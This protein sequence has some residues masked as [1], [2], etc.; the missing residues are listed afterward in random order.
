LLLPRTYIQILEIQKAQRRR[1][2]KAQRKRMEILSLIFL[3]KPRCTAILASTLVNFSSLHVKELDLVH[4]RLSSLER[5]RLPRF[6]THLQRLCLRQNFI[7]SL[8][9]EIFSLLTKLVELDL[10]DNK[11]KHI[12]DALNNLTALT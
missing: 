8:D 5:L 11:I 12:G 1:N 10:Y 9:P 3:T 6:A 2:M 7:S 4:S